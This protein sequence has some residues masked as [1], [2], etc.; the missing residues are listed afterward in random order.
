MF[1]YEHL[2]YW[3]PTPPTRSKRWFKMPGERAPQLAPQLQETSGKKLEV[4]PLPLARMD[5]ATSMRPHG[6]WLHT[7]G[8]EISH[9]RRKTEET[10]QGASPREGP[11]QD[12]GAQGRPAPLQGSISAPRLGTDSKEFSLP[13]PCR[14]LVAIAMP[15]YQVC[16]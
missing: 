3:I 15:G 13:G 16:V 7:G 10:E 6:L 2:Y 1:S 8:A 12:R 5:A 4:L 11:G 9:R 14:N